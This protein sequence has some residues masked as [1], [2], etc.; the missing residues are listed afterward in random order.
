VDIGKQQ[1]RELIGE[2]LGISVLE[3]IAIDIVSSYLRGNVL[4][5]YCLWDLRE[6]QN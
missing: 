3:D 1:K 4:G 6:R 2:D 5:L